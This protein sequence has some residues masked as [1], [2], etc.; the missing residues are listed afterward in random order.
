M[1]VVPAPYNGQLIAYVALAAICVALCIG[2]LHRYH[3]S[4]LLSVVVLAVAAWWLGE[5]T[6][7]VAHW[8]PHLYVF[9]FL[10]FA[11]AGAS[12]AVGGAG[13][14]PSF[15]FGAG[16]LVHGH[17]AFLLFVAV[18]VIAALAGLFISRRLGLRA[19]LRRP[20]LISAGIAG[21]FALPMLLEVILHYPGPWPKYLRYLHRHNHHHS[22]ALAFRYMAHYWP[23]SLSL[24]LI[25]AL[26]AAATVG[27]VITRPGLRGRRMAA[28][29]LGAA[30]L[31][32]AVLVF[33]ARDGIDRLHQFY[34]GHF[35]VAVP[36][37]VL[38]AALLALGG[39]L[40]D[41][42]RRAGRFATPAVLAAAG[43]ACLAAVVVAPGFMNTYRGNTHLPRMVA[44]VSRL[45]R[46][47]FPGPLILDPGPR[48]SAA[49]GFLV[50]A[51]RVGV[52][53]CVS[54]PHDELLFTSR[55]M[56]TRQQLRQ[57]PWRLYFLAEARVPPGLTP[58]WSDRRAAILKVRGNAVKLARRH[59]RVLS[60]G[61]QRTAA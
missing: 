59:K 43:A 44:V 42:F 39:T 7:M 20:V 1:H 21:L 47:S 57:T 9:P 49:A 41:P 61:A 18:G 25:F 19:S 30:V 12:V 13:D 5:H 14:L 31:L 11:V 22:L 10:I 54:N 6:P 16:M 35:Y 28:A 56:C 4:S 40:L 60:L 32:S 51:Q 45:T 24:Q 3:G 29:L 53:S 33:Y 48:W 26:L 17:V 15:V 55:S 2:V 52:A 38:F 36:L 8:F 37:L 27:L 50:Q 34:I 46:A 23:S 58:V